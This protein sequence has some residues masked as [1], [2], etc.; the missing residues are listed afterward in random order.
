MSPPQ[1]GDDK[2]DE[3]KVVGGSD[4]LDAKPAPA[5]SVPGTARRP[6]GRPA[7]RDTRGPI[8]PTEG[9]S[10]A[11][12]GEG[13]PAK[14]GSATLA[15]D[16]GRTPRWI[17]AVGSVALVGMFVFLALWLLK[18]T[19]QVAS[20][21]DTAAMRAA[22]SRFVQTYLNFNSDNLDQRLN[23]LADEGTGRFVQQ[24]DQYFG[25]ATRKQLKEA[26][27]ASKGEVHHLYVESFNKDDGTGTVFVS[28]DQTI[29]NNKTATPVSTTI[30]MVLTLQ[31]VRDEWK[32]SKLQ[33]AQAPRSDETSTSGSSTTGG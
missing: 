8:P 17:L 16:L 26:Q 12:G 28:A 27:S 13:P 25:D 3:V 29:A 20:P 31:K 6:S 4:R 21:K 14:V 2:P 33:V 11:A 18:P 30:R 15:N 10:P 7:R 32:V 22:A 9:A 19:N 23:A 5:R 24:F 1:E